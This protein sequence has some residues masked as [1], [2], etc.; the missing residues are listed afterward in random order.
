MGITVETEG[1]VETVEL[2]Q[3]IVD[4]LDQLDQLDQHLQ[5]VLCQEHLQVLPEELVDK[6]EQRVIREEMEIQV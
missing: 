5:Q 1:M 3:E 2:V 6:V 4:Q